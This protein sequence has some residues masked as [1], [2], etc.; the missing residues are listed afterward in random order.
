MIIPEEHGGLGFGHYAHATVVTRIATLNISAAVTVMVPNSLGPAELLLRY[1]TPAQ[2]QH[3]LPRLADGRDLPCF[4]LTS[5]YAGSDAASIPDSGVLV[6]RE[7]DGAMVRG[8][9]VNFSKRYITPGA[10]GHR[11]RPGLQ[12]HRREPARRPAPPGHHLRADPGAA[13]RHGHRQAAQAHG[14][15]LHEWPHRRPRGLH[16]HGLGHGRRSPGRPG[17]AHADGML[18][19]QAA[20]FRC[21]RWARRCSRPRSSSPTATARCASSS[22]FR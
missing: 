4:G 12:R 6:E 17:L 20:R 15:G 8:F 19:R 7:V 2:K 18:W 14:R 16:P 13:A 10:G 22:A 5:P 11:R 1:G 3:Y 21:R 9:S